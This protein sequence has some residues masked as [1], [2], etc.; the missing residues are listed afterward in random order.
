MDTVKKKLKRQSTGWEKIFANCTSDKGLVSRTYKKL[1]KSNNKK[2]T[3]VKNEQRILK[4]ILQKTIHWTIR[5]V[6]IEKM[7]DIISHQGNVNQMRYYLTP[8]RMTRVKL[9]QVL[10][11][12]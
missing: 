11:R 6:N 5:V 1:S 8:T 2:T 3:Q 7:L 4:K 12:I 10:V 9:R